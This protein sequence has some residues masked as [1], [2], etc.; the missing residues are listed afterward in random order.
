MGW[1]SASEIFDPIAQALIDLNANPATKRRVLGTL[2]STLRANDWDTEDES[3]DEFRHD[4]E[5][6]AIFYEQGVGN[7]FEGDDAD[8][9]LD[10]DAHRN[11][12]IL[13]CSRC[14]HFDT[15]DGSSAEEHDRLVRQWADHEASD[16][17]GDGNVNDWML[18]NRDGAS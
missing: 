11:R 3:L 4:A 17:D 2:I 10:Y 8:G 1:A 16:H 12:W 5:I 7:K 14:G 18:I 6:V 9:T 13:S 15:G